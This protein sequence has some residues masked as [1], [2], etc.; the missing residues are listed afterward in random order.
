MGKGLLGVDILTILA[1]SHGSLQGVCRW[2]TKPM[3]S[4]CVVK[5]STTRAQVARSGNANICVGDDGVGRV[6]RFYR[7]IRATLQYCTAVL[8]CVLP[9]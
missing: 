2:G 6:M 9:F 5:Q 1:K 7:E 3:S 8:G 4:H